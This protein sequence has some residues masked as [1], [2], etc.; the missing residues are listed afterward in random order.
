MLESGELEKTG[1]VPPDKP[2]F[3]KT[4]EI[5]PGTDWPVRSKNH[6]VLLSPSN[7]SPAADARTCGWS[8]WGNLFWGC[9][10]VV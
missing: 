2:V 9:P 8:A 6:L 1:V 3:D 7:H 10:R 5:L 4:L